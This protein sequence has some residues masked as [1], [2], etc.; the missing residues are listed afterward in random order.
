MEYEEEDDYEGE[1]E[2]AIDEEGPTASMSPTLSS[3]PA[4]PATKIKRLVRLERPASLVPQGATHVQGPFAMVTAEAIATVTRATEC[5]VEALARSAGAVASV[6][7]RRIV[8][9]RDLA[10]A[11][12]RDDR[13]QFTHD[14]I[15]LPVTVAEAL[16]IQRLRGLSHLQSELP[17]STT[18]KVDPTP[19]TSQSQ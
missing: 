8:G 14:L 1:G 3:G 11:V 16:E 5:F 7:H 4:F 18:P 13:F 15:P 12:R 19:V 2:M 17:S 10:E 6:A 9:L